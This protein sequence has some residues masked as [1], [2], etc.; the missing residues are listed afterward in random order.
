LADGIANTQQTTGVTNTQEVTPR[1]KT[2]GTAG[3]PGD[4]AGITHPQGT[5]EQ[6]NGTGS[7]AS[8]AMSRGARPGAEAW[9][10]FSVSGAP[11]P[12][13]RGE[14]RLARL[15]VETDVLQINSNFQQ[16]SCN[17]KYKVPT[18]TDRRGGTAGLSPRG[19]SN[20][21][22]AFLNNTSLSAQGKIAHKK[23]QNNNATDKTKQRGNY[24]IESS[25]AGR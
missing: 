14:A 11:G 16:Q 22:A 18:L 15:P 2:E 9:R 25:R 4:L 23:G 10:T 20:P 19:M 13:S 24:N 12:C 1:E 8:G 5:T 7:D 21:E 17:Q 3:R 6:H